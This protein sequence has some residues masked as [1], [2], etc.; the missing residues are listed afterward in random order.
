MCSLE[1]TVTDVT[2]KPNFIEA[3]DTLL[4]KVIVRPRLVVLAQCA[5]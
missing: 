2:K 1:F 4:L 3:N 5:A